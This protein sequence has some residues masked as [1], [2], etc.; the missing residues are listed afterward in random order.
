MD[1][2]FLFTIKIYDLINRFDFDFFTHCFHKIYD[3]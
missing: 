3:Y 2:V 1:S